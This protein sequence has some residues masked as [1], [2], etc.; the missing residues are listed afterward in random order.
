[1]RAMDQ[2]DMALPAEDGLWEAQCILLLW[3]SQLVLVPF[4][5]SLLDSSLQ[6]TDVAERCGSTPHSNTNYQAVMKVELHDIAAY[7]SFK[8]RKNLNPL[9]RSGRFSI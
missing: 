2:N 3:L 7:G 8:P 9:S 5:L 1:M 6:E 4:N